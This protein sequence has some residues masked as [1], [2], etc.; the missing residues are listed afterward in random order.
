MKNE[1]VWHEVHYPIALSDPLPAERRVVLVWCGGE[2]SDLVFAPWLGYIHYAAGCRD[3]P[4][5]VVYHGNRDLPVDVV[6][7]C[8][9][10]PNEGPA[11]LDTTEK[12]DREQ[13][14]GRGFPAR[15]GNSERGE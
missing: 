9:C 15:S 6:A 5:F 11:W 14:A 1:P 7:W 4:V 10:L 12:H 3:S 2:K 13:P 8:D